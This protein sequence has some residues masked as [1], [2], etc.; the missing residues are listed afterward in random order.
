MVINNDPP[1]RKCHSSTVWSENLWKV[2]ELWGWKFVHKWTRNVCVAL[3]C[4]AKRRS[5]GTSV[6]W[7][8][9]RTDTTK[10]VCSAKT[11]HKNPQRKIFQS[12]SLHTEMK[13]YI[14]LREFLYSLYLH[15]Q[16]EI[17]QQLPINF[18]AVASGPPI[19]RLL[20]AHPFYNIMLVSKN[21][22]RFGKPFCYTTVLQMST[23]DID[24]FRTNAEIPWRN[25]I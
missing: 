8:P 7:L 15:R 16:T 24:F 23:P 12:R 22:I 1:M 14:R 3:V 25:E 19:C 11:G 2:M 6:N 4:P 18:S 5:H 20:E 13:L 10:T 17:T 21:D 9:L